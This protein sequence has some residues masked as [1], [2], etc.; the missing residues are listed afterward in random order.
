M[1]SPIYLFFGFFGGFRANVDE[2]LGDIVVLF[3]AYVAEMDRRLA[4]NALNWLIAVDRDVLA[5]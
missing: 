5:L 3:A 1:G 4:D 2:L